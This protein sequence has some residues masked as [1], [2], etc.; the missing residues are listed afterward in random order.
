MVQANANYWG[1]ASIFD[2]AACGV[3]EA[4]KDLAR[5]YPKQHFDVEAV[6]HA[7]D[8]VKVD[9]SHC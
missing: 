2:S 4:T 8:V 9:Y 5:K 7:F 3:I 6:Q 1:S